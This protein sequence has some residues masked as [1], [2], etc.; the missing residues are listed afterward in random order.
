[1]RRLTAALI[2]ALC[3][4]TTA[5][6]AAAGVGVGVNDDTGKY[7]DGDAQFWTTLKENGLKQNAM[8][9][10]WDETR[11]ATIAEEGYIRNSLAAADAAGVKVVFDVYPM[12]SRAL[13]SDRANVARF[14]AFVARLATTFPQVHEFVVMNECNQTRFVNPQFGAKKQNQSAALCGQALAAAYDALKAVDQSIFV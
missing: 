4:F 12:H 8:T 11:P 14:G 13:T 3:A 2:C 7:A 9:V 5:G 6:T 10:L 1:M